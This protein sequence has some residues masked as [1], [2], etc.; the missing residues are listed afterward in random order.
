MI[1]ITKSTFVP[2]FFGHGD[3]DNFISPQHMISI[4]SEYAGESNKLIFP[5]THNSVRPTFF[6]ISVSIFLYNHLI[7]IDDYNSIY[8]C[9]KTLIN[10]CSR[11]SFTERKII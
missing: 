5:G 7:K 6:N 10:E 2:A 4:Q 1:K 9:L 8:F 11:K 3:S